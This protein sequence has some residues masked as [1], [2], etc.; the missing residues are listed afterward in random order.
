MKLDQ[1]FGFLLIVLAIYLGVN[2]TARGDVGGGLFD[3][4]DDP[5][6]AV[7]DG[8]G[9]PDPGDDVVVDDAPADPD[10]ETAE[11]RR[12]RRR[13]AER[14]ITGSDFCRNAPDRS[15]YDDLGRANDAA[16]RCMEAAG[17]VRGVSGDT[18]APRDSLTRAQAA[19]TIAG[20]IDTANRLER[21]DVDLRELQD[22]PDARFVDV[23][24]DHRAAD[25]IARL[26]EAGIIEGFVDARYEPRGRVTRGQ[27]A[28]ILDRSYQ[29]LTGEALPAGG[30]RFTDDDESVHEDSINAVAAAGIM[31]G[32]GD[33]QFRPG[34]SVNRGP[35][36][37]FVARTMIRLEETNRIR[38]L[39]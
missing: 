34:D 36:A 33:R 11:E 15:R 30:D 28:S 16:I 8:P 31:E 12:R 18:Y 29:Y 20:M 9:E 19:D 23:P 24:P 26:N 27:M 22:A 10:P 17:V 35:M 38:P 4:P 7:D 14:D 25:D 37:T 6:A 5:P 39:D 32:T 13:A 21:P 1:V 2:A 3:G